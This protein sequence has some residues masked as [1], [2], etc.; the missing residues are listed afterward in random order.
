MVLKQLSDVTFTLIP[1]LKNA[2]IKTSKKFK[3]R[4][5]HKTRRP[6]RRHKTRRKHSTIKRRIS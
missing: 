6:N 4:H 1:I 3:T 5:R 2:T